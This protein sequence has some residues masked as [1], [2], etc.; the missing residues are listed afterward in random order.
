MSIQFEQLRDLID[1]LE[2]ETSQLTPKANLVELL[3]L[4]STE[5]AEL[6]REFQKKF[7]KKLPAMFLY[8]QCIE[9]V[10]TKL[11]TAS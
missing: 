4:D 8:D 6:C 11:N 7:S 3:A 5:V 1:E 9:D 2:Y 10:L